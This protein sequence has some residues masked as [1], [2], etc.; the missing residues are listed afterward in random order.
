MRSLIRSAALAALVVMTAAAAH[1]ENEHLLQGNWQ[2]SVTS[3]ALEGTP[4]RAQIV[5]LKNNTFHATLY[6]EQK[7][8]E[9]VA[10]EVSG[11]KPDK[12]AIG[13]YE[14][15][16]DPG[17]KL[18]GKQ[19]L[20]GTV[21]DQVFTGALSHKDKKS[22][23]ELKRVE[24]GS[25]TLGMAPPEGATI[26]MDGKSLDAMIVQP[27]WVIDG[28][29]GA[30]ISGSSI[31]SKAEFGDAQYH[32]EFRNPY[33]PEEDKGSQA[34]GNSG[35]YLMGRYELQV[36]DSFTDKP[37]DNLCGGIYQKAVPIVLASLPPM[38]WQTYDI[39]FTAPKFDAAGKK[40]SD[41]R[42]TVKH[43]GIL[44]HDDAVLDD[45]TPGGVSGEEA[46]QGPLMLQDHHDTVTYRNIWVKPLG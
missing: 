16:V 22:E 44:I 12:V 18:G 30:H 9:E 19:T 45:A 46:P 28:E 14:G 40:T 27:H 4:L 2:G 3:G 21:K 34:R 1:A 38:E 25:P 20:T 11:K 43:N 10:V 39:T 8:G 15:E 26:L 33:M 42:I 24:L 32:V 23:F 5:G 7:G 36:L 41:A 13:A 31:V 35:V 17:E 37:K 6:F 29:G